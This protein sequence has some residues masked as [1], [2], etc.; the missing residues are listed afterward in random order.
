MVWTVENVNHLYQ[1]FLNWGLHVVP[2]GSMSW[3]DPTLLFFDALLL[4]AF[5]SSLFL[6]PLWSKNMIKNY[7]TVF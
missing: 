5:F 2:K 4:Q 7:T 6:L 1:C 3:V